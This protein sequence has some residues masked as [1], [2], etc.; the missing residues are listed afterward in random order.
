[1]AS[2]HGHTPH[3]YEHVQTHT[4][5]HTH[6]RART[7]THARAYNFYVTQHSKL[8]LIQCTYFIRLIPVYPSD[9]VAILRSVVGPMSHARSITIT[10]TTTITT[11]LITTY[12]TLSDT[13]ISMQTFSER[14]RGLS[15]NFGL[16]QPNE[17]WLTRT[18]VC[19]HRTTHDARPPQHD[20]L[21]T[22]TCLFSFARIVSTSHVSSISSSLCNASYLDVSIRDVIAWTMV[23][24]K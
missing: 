13:S 12:C 8:A 17:A 5:T 18:S 20:H 6:T 21:S 19:L 7:H 11:I 24:A 4:H 23:V 9:P 1:M 2:R 3:V 15:L 10:T 16:V 22:C 14:V